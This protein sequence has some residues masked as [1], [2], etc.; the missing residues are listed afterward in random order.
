M[1]SILSRMLREAVVTE[2]ALKSLLA[3]RSASC[4]QCK[5]IAGYPSTRGAYSCRCLR[6]FE[7]MHED[8]KNWLH[9]T[10]IEME[11]EKKAHGLFSRWE[12]SS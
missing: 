3:N 7:Y 6:G 5:P 2:N 8:G 4:V 12:D 10:L 1:E 9:G 11:D